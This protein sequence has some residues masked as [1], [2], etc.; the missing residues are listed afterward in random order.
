MTRQEAQTHKDAISAF[1]NGAE[2][3]MRQPDGTYWTPTED[4][5]WLPDWHYRVRKQ[6]VDV[7]AENERLREIIRRASARFG[8]G[9][10]DAETAVVMWAILGEAE[11]KK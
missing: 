8:A 7:G 2:I 3:E 10:P 5:G 9:G 1:V 4:P 11:V 6:V